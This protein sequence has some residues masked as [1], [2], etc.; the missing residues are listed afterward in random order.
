MCREVYVTS[1]KLWK[2]FLTHA[3]TYVYRYTHIINTDAYAHTYA[4]L[5]MYDL[6]LYYDAV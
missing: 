6:T 2:P 1:E 5:R 3:H 4:Y